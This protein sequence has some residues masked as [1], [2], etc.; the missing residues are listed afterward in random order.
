[1]TEHDRYM[2]GKFLRLALSAYQRWKHP[3]RNDSKKFVEDGKKQYH[4][5]MKKIREINER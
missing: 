1:M 3:H 2:R 4:S 5:C